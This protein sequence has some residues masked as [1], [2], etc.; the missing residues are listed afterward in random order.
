MDYT[1]LGH[2]GLSVSRLCLG[3]MN[4]GPQTSEADSHA[5]MDAAH[6]HGI[7]FFDTANRYGGDL[8]A[9]ATESI[10]GRWFATGGGRRERTGL[11]TKLYGSMGDWPNETKLSALNIRR[12]CDGSLR[13]LQTDH[14][15]LY[16]MHH[17]DRAT[18]WE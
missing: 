4:F 7:N 9:G 17:V 15:D 5:I 10:I 1:H 8:G 11:A 3:T 2:S 16:K 13:R 12:A 14:I 6:D 18:P